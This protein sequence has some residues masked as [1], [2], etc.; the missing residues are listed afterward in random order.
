MSGQ[1][2]AELTRAAL[3]AGADAFVRKRDLYDELKR[4]VAEWFGSTGSQN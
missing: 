4:L 1:Q 3:G 2:G